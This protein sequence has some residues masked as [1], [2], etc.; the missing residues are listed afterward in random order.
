MTT[1]V[2][3]TTLVQERGHKDANTLTEGFGKEQFQPAFYDWL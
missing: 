1:D 3:I 2:I